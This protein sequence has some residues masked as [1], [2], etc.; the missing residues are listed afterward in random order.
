MSAESLRTLLVT[1]SLTTGGAERFSA[2]LATHLERDLFE[3]ELFVASDGLGYRVP[4]DTQVTTHGYSGVH[5]L[6]RVVFRLRERLRR[7]PVPDIVV[8]NVLSTSCL[9]GAARGAVGVPWVARIGLAPGPGDPRLQSWF[10]H[11]AYRWATLVV[12]NSKA[13]AEAVQRRYPSTRGVVQVVPNPTDFEELDCRAVESL[14]EIA[15]REKGEL[16][17]L[18]VG[19]LSSQ[20]R[21]D[22]ALR[23]LAV[24]RREHSV[25]LWV[26]GSGPQGPKLRKIVGE[27]G[28]E[29]AVTWLGFC[30][31]PFVLMEHADLFLLSS[32]YEGLPNALIEAQGLG[33]PAVATDCPFG[34]SEIVSEG[35]SGFLVRPDDPEAL[36]KAATPLLASSEARS[37]MG[38]LA[39]I[40]TRCTYGLSVVMPQ[41]QRLL[42]EAV[43]GKAVRGSN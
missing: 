13:M 41:W 2:N 17:L 8:S 10:A 19:R 35:R 42:R 7:T 36:A 29:N 28:L 31:N 21:L 30:D 26:A 16:I 18:W 39:R 3:P 40:E 38:A 24:L 1:H 11:R 6:P 20:K 34:P 32:D 33:L 25:R 15:R 37:T 9:V 12:S 23:A 22:V 14:P 4:P 5:H 43:T 27:L